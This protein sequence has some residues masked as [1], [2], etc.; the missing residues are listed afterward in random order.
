MNKR[1][2][3]IPDIYITDKKYGAESSLAKI[4]YEHY[5]ET[6]MIVKEDAEKFTSQ[7]IE[8]FVKRINEKHNKKCLAIAA[9]S[10]I[11][12]VDAFIAS[13]T[14]KIKPPTEE[15]MQQIVDSVE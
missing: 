2:F 6:G 5:M 9:R 4:I 3:D 15:T 1:D 11:F 13:I 8:E 7:Y 12:G 10:F 14:H